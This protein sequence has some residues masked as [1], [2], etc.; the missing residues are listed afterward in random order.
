MEPSG[1]IILPLV[2]NENTNQ[3]EE[4]FGEKE[5]AGIEETNERV[6]CSSVV[7]NERKNRGRELI[8]SPLD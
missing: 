2:E 6:K 5:D 3:E 8:Y 7:P 4:E 1:N